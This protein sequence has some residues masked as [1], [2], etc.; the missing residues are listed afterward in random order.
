MATKRHKIFNL[1]FILIPWLSLLFIGKR[2][3][4]RY[5]FA[6]VFIVLFEILN[7]MYGHKRH[8]WRFYEKRKS[9]L[10]DELPFTIGPYMPLSMWILKYSYGNFKKFV[11]LNV[12]SDG[13]FAFLFVNILKKM[14]IARLNRLNHI[15]FFI[16]LH[17][18]AYLLYGVQ[19]LFEKFKR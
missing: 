11:L 12:I 5:S 19:Y 13:L 6:G 7:H 3:I 18:K 9:F 2:S 17:Y 16:Y 8:W 1:L 4:R 10:R 14:K 15:Q